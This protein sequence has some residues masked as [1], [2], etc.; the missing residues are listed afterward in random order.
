MKFYNVEKNWKKMKVGMKRI[1]TKNVQKYV[2][3]NA[4]KDRTLLLV[5]LREIN[6]K[7]QSYTEKMQGITDNPGRKNSKLG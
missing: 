4:K 7:S 1:K 2:I 3:K 5:M 6:T